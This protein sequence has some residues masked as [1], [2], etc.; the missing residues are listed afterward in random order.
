MEMNGKNYRIGKMNALAQFHV[1][2]RLLPALAT[3][4]IGLAQLKELSGVEDLVPLLAPISEVVSKMSD[5]DANYIIFT[6]LQVVSREEVTEPG[7]PGRF[8]PVV[9][10]NQLMYMDIDMMQMLRLAAEVVKENLGGFLTV[11]GG[12]TNSP[13]T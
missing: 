6:C 12:E 8:A 3:A 1:A 11:P 5:S 9:S 2:R 10:G 4:G 13:S 7:K